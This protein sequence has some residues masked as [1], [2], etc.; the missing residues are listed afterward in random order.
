M[1]SGVDVIRHTR[2]LRNRYVK[3]KA[4]ERAY[5]NEPEIGPLGALI[6]VPALAVACTLGLGWFIV[7]NT[8]K[9]AGKSVGTLA[10]KETERKELPEASCISLIIC[11]VICP[12]IIAGINYFNVQ[13]VAP[14]VTPV[15][16]PQK[17]HEI[18]NTAETPISDF[19]QEWKES[20][21]DRLQDIRDTLG[22]E[23]ED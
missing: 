8:A 13:L 18:F 15:M 5:P 9:L 19:F 1:G 2:R 7:K 17:Q 3:V 16:A 12:L 10:P 21:N 4:H 20:V 6:I 14:E 22:W 23:S 11:L